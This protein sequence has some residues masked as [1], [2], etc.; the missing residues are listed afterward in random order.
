MRSGST[1]PAAASGR[2]S[3]APTGL[4]DIVNG[5]GPVSIDGYT[6]PGASA[7]TLA[8]G[9]NAVLL[10]ELNGD[11]AAGA[12]LYVKANGSTV[13]GLVI[14]RFTASGI[15]VEAVGVTIAGNYLGTDASGTVDRGNGNHGIVISG[16]TSTIGGTT[17][18]DRNVISGNDLSGIA[19]LGS[20]TIQGNYIG[21]DRGGTAD[22][23][24]DLPGITGIGGP[25][26]LG[27]TV[28]GPATSSRLM[29]AASIS[30]AE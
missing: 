1:S 29:R 20:V 24:N 19:N 11:G 2:S 22:L 21:T 30:A 10:I 17:P 13:R 28:T 14:N 3:S 27:G 7:N 26:T 25:L 8:V 16:G 4:P 15:R 5:A 23:G 9:G 6:Q 12:G 18:A